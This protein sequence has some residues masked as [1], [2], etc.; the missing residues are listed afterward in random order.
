MPLRKYFAGLSVN[1]FLLALASLFADI[2]TEMLYP[3]LPGFLTGT[4]HAGPT[5][6]GL[7]DGLATAVQNVVQ[8]VSGWVSDRLDRR[9]P[10]ALVGYALAAFAKP[11]IGLAEAWP[12]VLAARSL[13]RLGAGT[14]SAPRDALVAA[15][16]DDASRGKA[17]GLEG[18]GDNLGA[19]LGPFIGLFALSYVALPTVFLLAFIPGALAALMVA[20]VR[21][22]RIVT[23]AKAT[24]D[25]RVGRFPRAYWTYLAVTALFG[26]GNSTN[27][28]LI[29][30]LPV[31]TP[32]STVVLIYAGYNLVAALASYPAGHLS[33][34]LGRRTVLLLAF[35]VF[36][37]TYAG[38]GLTT[39]AVVLGGLFVLYGIF[40]GVFRAVGKALVTDLV[41]AELR[42]SGVGWYMATVGISGLVAS[43]IGGELWTRV[44][45]AATF[46]YGAIMALAGSVALTQ[47]VPRRLAAARQ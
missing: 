8:G 24:L 34:I 21:E 5:A 4:L 46:Y 39:N 38:F 33:D 23:T 14:R 37:V 26:I 13:D 40:H 15:S 45:P 25:V 2:S 36:A 44:D 9:K 29:L 31:G 11:L 7:I 19:F 20:L 22:R 32:I 30:R 27:M 42:A 41:P 1:T 3:L 17:F 12:A 16:A 47:F 43:V 10:V 6:V 35:V 18:V 28:F